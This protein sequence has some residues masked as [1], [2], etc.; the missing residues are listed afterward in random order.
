M[1]STFLRIATGIL[2]VFVG[3]SVVGQP[4]APERAADA[5]L[6]ATDAPDAPESWCPLC[7]R[8]RS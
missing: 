1:R 6:T 3:T 2:Y 7:R 8:P 5:K 4:Q